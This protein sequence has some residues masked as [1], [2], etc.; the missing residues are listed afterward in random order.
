MGFKDHTKSGGRGLN[1]T[2]A[3]VAN[4]EHRLS[5]KVHLPHMYNDVKNF[6]GLSV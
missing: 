1:F 2:P 5:S 6:L 4:V 3:T